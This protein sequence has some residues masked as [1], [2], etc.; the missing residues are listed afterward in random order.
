MFENLNSCLRTY[1]TL[2][3]QLGTPY[4]DLLQFFLS[5][6]RLCA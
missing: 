3:F 1:F 2:R 5:H 6:A 4:L